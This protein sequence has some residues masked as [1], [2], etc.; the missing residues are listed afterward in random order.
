MSTKFEAEGLSEVTIVL[1]DE[2][3]RE[4]DR[5]TASIPGQYTFHVNSPGRYKVYLLLKDQAKLE[6]KPESRSTSFKGPGR[7]D[8]HLDTKDYIRLLKVGVPK[9]SV[10]QKGEDLSSDRPPHEAIISSAIGL[11][12]MSNLGGATPF[13]EEISK[14]LINPDRSNFPQEARQSGARQL[15][16]QDSSSNAPQRQRYNNLSTEIESRMRNCIQSNLI[17]LLEV[18]TLASY[19]E[20]FSWRDE[21]DNELERQLLFLYTNFNAVRNAIEECDPTL[22]QQINSAE[23]RESTVTVIGNLVN[24]RSG[25]GTSFSVISQVRYGT[26]LV[27]D[28]ETEISLSFLDLLAIEQGNGWQ[29]I[30]L[31]DGRRGYI[32]SLY[33]E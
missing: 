13:F 6:V 28:L 12:L 10:P 33:I 23:K 32:F 7:I 14:Q 21:P 19:L 27:V 1:E 2:S 4:V 5:G 3:G 18:P 30:L 8:V 29:P 31:S 25:S 16:N 20:S 26:I 22:I 15:G 24:I 17:R 11:A 9:I